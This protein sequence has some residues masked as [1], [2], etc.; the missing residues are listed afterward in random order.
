MVALARVGAVNR[1]PLDVAEGAG[2]ELAGEELVLMRVCHLDES[3]GE[4]CPQ[5]VR[6]VGERGVADDRAA[7]EQP[8]GSLGKFGC[9]RVEKTACPFCQLPR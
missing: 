6:V 8:G 9:V 5:R 2:I 7:R 3:V 4:S 1:S